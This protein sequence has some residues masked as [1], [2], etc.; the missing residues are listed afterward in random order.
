VAYPKSV[1]KRTVSTGVG[2]VRVTKPPATEV[3]FRY[4]TDGLLVDIAN[5]YHPRGFKLTIDEAKLLRDSINQ[6]FGE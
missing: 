2:Y 6:W 3:N 4:H 1:S 5:G